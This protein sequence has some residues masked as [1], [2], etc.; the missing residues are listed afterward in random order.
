MMELNIKLVLPVM[1]PLPI[2]DQQKILQEE[3]L[4][5]V[6]SLSGKVTTIYPFDSI[7]DEVPLFFNI[8]QSPE[9][10]TLIKK[11]WKPAATGRKYKVIEVI[12]KVNVDFEKILADFIR[13]NGEG[14]ITLDELL[15]VVKDDVM[16]EII[17][18]I[19]IFI[20]MCN[21][22][23]PGSISLIEG[24]SFLE[25]EYYKPIKSFYTEHLFF[26]MEAAKNSWPSFFKINIKDARQWLIDYKFIQNGVGIGSTGRAISA[27]SYVIP[28]SFQS[29]NIDLAWILLGLEALY[30]K[31]NVGLKN[32]LLEKTELILGKRSSNK[33]AFGAMY[34]FRSRLLHGDIDLPLR[35]S[36]F[37]T[38]RIEDFDLEISANEKIALAVL[39]ATLQWMIKNR[40]SELQFAYE[41]MN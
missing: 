38:E 11:I 14:K 22:V 20:L 27:L 4:E 6:M 12:A 26:A 2:F 7:Y 21:T 40:K 29:N 34:D 30:T 36:E 17:Y 8:Y 9:Q 41:L 31:N 5:E 24:Y 39:I 15:G 3:C 32:Q 10:C 1:I 25:N 16:S 33:K 13:E 23:R 37:D 28:E 35:F 19:R 18:E